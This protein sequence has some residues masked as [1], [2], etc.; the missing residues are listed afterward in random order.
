MAL[1]LCVAERKMRLGGWSPWCYRGQ[2]GQRG[3][4]PIYAVFG[5]NQTKSNMQLRNSVVISP[6]E[7]RRRPKARESWHANLMAVVGSE[8]AR[9]AVLVGFILLVALTGGSSRPD[10]PSLVVLRPASVMFCFYALCAATL[11]QLRM[12]RA[13][14]LV[15]LALMLLAILQLV[16]LPAAWW[17]GLA[18]RDLVAEAS[19]LL[20]MEQAGRPLSLDPNRTWNTFFALFVPLATI[21]LAAL[22]APVKQSL[23]VPTLMTLGLLNVVLGFLQAVGGNG[24]HLYAITHSDFPVGLFANRNHQAVMLLWLMLA[25]GWFA[26]TASSNRI[27]AGMAIGGALA[28]IFVLFPLLVLTG[29]RTGL[30]LSPIALLLSG[31]LMFRSPATKALLRRAGK[32]AGLLLGGAVACLATP[33]LL[34]I[35]VLA[36]SERQSALSRLFELDAADDLRWRY[37]PALLRMMWEFMPL[38]SGFG[39]FES[40]VRMFEPGSLLAPRYMN[41]AHNDFLQ[42]AIEGGLPALA[43][44]VVGLI[45]YWRCC[46]RLWRSGEPRGQTHAVFFVGSLLL[47]LAAST[48]DYPLRTPLAMMLVAALT[49]QLSFLSTTAY[50]R[51]GAPGKQAARS[52]AS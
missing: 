18:K 27:S 9:F 42:V 4:S 39:S 32:R 40:V 25:V 12:A 50:S 44:F 16:P 46:W 36:T 3:K 43:V 5:A 37:M 15:V 13:P 30:A 21:G 17:T 38:G 47:W 48:V 8:R 31:W 14:L 23:I 49:A 33:L 41:Q 6:L 22:Q 35:V 24:L 2:R 51:R 45:W 28:A 11:C 1:G 29:S 7:R 52:D 20:G 34:V 10:I 26:A 19:R